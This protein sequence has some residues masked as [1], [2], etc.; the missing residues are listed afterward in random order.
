MNAELIA[1]FTPENFGEWCRDRFDRFTGDL[2]PIADSGGFAHA[3][4]IGYVQVL[5]DDETNRPLLVMAVHAGANINERSS[6]RRQ[7]D[8]ARRQLQAAM[9]NPPAKVKGLFTQGLF[10]FYDDVGNFRL[11][12]ITG[13]AEG[14]H[15]VYGD[16]KRQ[17]FFVAPERENKT[18]RARMAT[19]FASWKS[20]V[21]AFSVE[22]LTKEFYKSLFAW[23]ERAMAP[24]SKVSFPN[25]V[26]RDDDNRDLLA[27]HLIRLI[28]RLMFVWFIRQKK[29]IPDTLFNPDELKPLLK[30]F[31]ATSPKQDNYYRAILQNL[32]F[33]TLNCEIGER[34]F[35][36]E[37]TRQ[38]N[39]EHFGIKIL[40]RYR[41][42]FA[43]PTD[44]V[45]ELFRSVPFLNGGLFEC[46]DKKR[47]ASA[48]SPLLYQ[49]GFSREPDKRAHI[50][51]HLFFDEEG[52][53]TLFARYDFT[54]DENAPNDSDVALDPELLGKVFENLLGAYN[55][56]TKQT[57]RKQSGS[58][59]TPREIVNYMVDES[60]KAHLL[61]KVGQAFLPAQSKKDAT[62]RKPAPPS[63]A[64]LSQRIEA[65]FLPDEP[66]GSFTA[67]ERRALVEALYRCRILDPA[68]GSGAFPMG[69]LLKMVHLLQRLDPKNT[70]WHEIVM[71]ETERDL[72]EAETL[73]QV[74][75]DERLRR[76]TES[77][78]H[79]VNQPD[80]A[81]KLYLIENCI[82]G[83]DIQSIAVQIAKLRAFIT[84]V[85]DQTPTSDSEKN[86]GMLP[87]PNL[88][89]KFVAANTLIG[90]AT[91]FAEG[92]KTADNV[93][94][95]NDPDLHRLRAELAEVRHRHFR[96]RSAPEKN[97]CRKVDKSLRDRIK[98]RLVEIASKPDALKIALWQAEIEKLWQQRKNVEQED[99]REVIRTDPVQG[100]MFT[101]TPKPVQ[102]TLRMDV[103]K[104][105]RDRI[106]NAIRQLSG[107]IESEQ[108]RARNKSAFQHEADRLAAWDPYDQNTSSPFFDPEWMFDV[109]SG[110]DIVIGNPP[111]IS[112]DRLPYPDV[113]KQFYR[114]WSPFADIYC[115]FAERGMDLLQQGGTLAFITSNSYI[116]A[117]YG[118][119][120]RRL[121]GA[122]NTLTALVNIE[123]SQ[124]FESAIVNTAI[125]I[126]KKCLHQSN[127]ET[128][129]CNDAVGTLSFP[130]YMAQYATLVPAS[131]FTC[132][133]WVLTNERHL[134]LLDKIRSAGRTLKDRGVKIRLGI[135]TGANSA[136]IIDRKQ[137]AQ[138]IKADKKNGVILK[139]IL[140]GRDIQRFQLADSG[141]F[142]IL[143]KNG[144]NVKDDYP[145]LYKHLDS[146]G[147]A[148]RSRGAKGRHWWN[149]RACD[150]Y[151][152]F[153]K[154]KI[155][156]M[157]LTDR[158]RFALCMEEIYCI[159]TAYFML[160]PE[161][162]DI[163]YLTGLLNSSVVE[164]Y[165]K[166]Q[167]ETSGMGTCRW[168]NNIVSE[169]PVPD[170]ESE[171]CN[172]VSGL[173]S[174]VTEVKA[175]DPNADVAV[176]EAEIDRLVYQLYDLTPEEI[177]IVEGREGG[178]K[179][180][181][182]AA[183][184]RKAVAGA[185]RKARKSVL[186]EDPDLA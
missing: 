184:R 56:E 179:Q 121:F 40:Y 115:Y 61:T 116:K 134:R 173:V 143:A 60:L 153:K 83:V 111:Y 27:E 81:R 119:L 144:I 35:A 155:V 137:R 163:R 138:F 152:D 49:D 93:S 148:F 100:D 29:L 78:D 3:D 105:P 91:D 171:H 113:L 172:L 89:T 180:V 23:Y 50:P 46:L 90:L 147:T 19:S 59:Y 17:S 109:K 76:I 126:V 142:V 12:L 186:T 181:A 120:M 20:L 167:A 124:V 108:N 102:T 44:K 30:D 174:R 141:Q 79:N 87:L 125:A 175:R 185:K 145:D 177:A 84:L 25:D 42:E 39:K 178:G 11:S 154:P 24:T 57:A 4:I 53:I 21:E 161:V 114:T 140:R 16:F 80:Y 64:P 69:V 34:E 22:T 36:T 158:P 37:G 129:V 32:F 26:A 127:V 103:N 130:A 164:F 38:Q 176:M 131:R 63:S 7:F 139:P 118:L 151:D 156:W 45:I 47:D 1:Q 13:R 66:D 162:L 2:H 170:A 128:V 99:W 65:L 73:S 52:L 41:D 6:R 14:R 54:V 70:L 9:E 43:C 68:C 74:E 92:L 98:A 15:L 96:A 159:N 86:Y 58:F 122:D 33:A 146:F 165:V 166:H 160:P 28:T 107:H 183:K 77:F 149:L 67:A 94:L 97:K 8:F 75:K 85:C 135:A 136:F 18:F 104:E 51:N 123:D 88:E 112:H 71:A 95:L 48:R 5:P 110:F 72:A 150:F 55:P 31:D 133:R 182:A 62:A 106:D 117:E 168:I 132:K 157:E 10:A 101:T 169:V 82:Y